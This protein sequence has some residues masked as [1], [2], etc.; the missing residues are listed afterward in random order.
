MAL[1][2]QENAQTPK[3]HTLKKL[4]PNWKGGGGAL[5][6]FPHPFEPGPSP[7]PQP[8]THW[9]RRLTFERFLLKELKGSEGCLVTIRVGVSVQSR[10]SKVATENRVVLE[11]SRGI[12]PQ[13]L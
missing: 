3:V 4:P 9:G 6:R 2:V 13:H 11:R 12:A 8:W 7:Q 5:Q 10:H 1:D